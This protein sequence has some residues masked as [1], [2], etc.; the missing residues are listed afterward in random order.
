MKSSNKTS[1]IRKKFKNQPFFKIRS[2]ISSILYFISP[3][4][5]SSIPK[6][7]EIGSPE[8]RSSDYVLTKSKTNTRHTV[9]N[10]QPKVPPNLPLPTSADQT[11]TQTKSTH[12]SRKS[13]DQTTAA[14]IEAKPT[15]SQLLPPA[16]VAQLPNPTHTKRVSKIAFSPETK[17]GSNSSPHPFNTVF[18]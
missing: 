7:P 3:D 18:N 16:A 17:R 11:Q 4:D 14:V 5:I 10:H 13:V 8:M 2:R 6:L 1:P 9:E 12:V 15:K